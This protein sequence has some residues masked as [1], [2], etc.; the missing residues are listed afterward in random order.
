VVGCCEHGSEP[1]GSIKGGEFLTNLVS[2]SLSRRTPPHGLSQ[3]V[4]ELLGWLLV[5]F[6]GLLY[7]TH[8]SSP[9]FLR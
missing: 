4:S 2:I 9:S 5:S 1:S 7:V 6:L 8:N 3:S